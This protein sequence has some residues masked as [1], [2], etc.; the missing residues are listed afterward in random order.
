MS[1]PLYNTLNKN[2]PLIIGRDH[3]QK[4]FLETTGVDGG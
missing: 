1:I 4:E 3:E 2:Y